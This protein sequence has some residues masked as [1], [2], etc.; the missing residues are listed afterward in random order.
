MTRK[1]L[2]I[3]AGLMMLGGAPALAQEA[4]PLPQNTPAAA[5]TT[6][7]TPQAPGQYATTTARIG[8]EATAREKLTAKGYSNIERIEQRADG[9]W[10]ATATKDNRKK[11]VVVRADG[12]IT[13]AG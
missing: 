11:N 9:T 4:A 6:P 5:P 13:P 3:A 7:A 12:S 2:A 8:D 10:M 1:T